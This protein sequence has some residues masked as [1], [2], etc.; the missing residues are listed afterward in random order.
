MVVVRS[1]LPSTDLD[2]ALARKGVTIGC[3]YQTRTMMRS[4]GLPGLK[5]VRP[6]SKAPLYMGSVSSSGLLKLLTTRTSM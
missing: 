2:R 1:T 6:G 4:P 5:S 3:P